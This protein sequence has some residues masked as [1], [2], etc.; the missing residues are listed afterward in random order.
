V[1]DEDDDEVELK[2]P[3]SRRR[4][5]S[6][7][8][9]EADV[10][11]LRE[12]LGNFAEIRLPKEAEE[13]I[14]AR[15]VR[16]A[17]FEWMHEIRAEEDLKAVGLAARPTAMLYGPPGCGKT[18]LAHHLA[19]RLGSPLVIM[20][21]GNVLSPYLAKGAQNIYA[22]FKIIADY[23]DKLVILLDEFDSIGHAR[24]KAGG[25]GWATNEKNLGVNTLL[26]MIEGFSGI[27]LAATNR[28]DSIDP[29]L[30]R[31]FKMQIEITIPGFDERFAILKR[32]GMPYEFADEV[33]DELAHLTDGAAPSLLRD[34]MEGLKRALTLGP[35]MKRPIDD[36]VAMIQAI[37]AKVAPHPDYDQPPL[38]RA[39]SMAK[40]LAKLP[41][42]PTL[43]G[44]S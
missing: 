20:E 19:A 3:P 27:L 30:W 6:E 4:R 22:F 10:E 42:P 35:R 2:A 12:T 8:A 13:P 41:W 36:P 7:T 16:E 43:P 21:A 1:A 33:I 5:R 18:T 15:P 23:P 14:L 39:P 37:A 31:R 11:R 9:D 29:A 40:N 24:E 17:I 28:Q 26:R 34:V 38:W 44:K 32:Y 25:G